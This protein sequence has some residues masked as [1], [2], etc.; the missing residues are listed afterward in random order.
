MTLRKVVATKAY[1]TAERLRPLEIDG[2]PYFGTENAS[3][4]ESIITL[5]RDELK[6][7]PG[8]KFIDDQLSSRDACMHLKRIMYTYAEFQAKR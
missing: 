7:A 3:N 1:L 2:T 5:V 6:N 8:L 4:V